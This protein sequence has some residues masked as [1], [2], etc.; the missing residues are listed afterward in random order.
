MNGSCDKQ[1]MSRQ[2]KTTRAQ[3]E[4]QDGAGPDLCPH[5]CSGFLLLEV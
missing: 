4:A 2:K 1:F 3:A 5:A